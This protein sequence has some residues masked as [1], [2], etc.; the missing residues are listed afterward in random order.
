MG[1]VRRSPP[2]REVLERFF[3]L[4]DVDRELVAKRRGDHSRLLGF[5]LQLVTVR[6]VGYSK[7]KTTAS[8]RSLSNRHP[9]DFP[10]PLPHRNRLDTS[11]GDSRTDLTGLFREVVLTGQTE[12]ALAQVDEANERAETAEQAQTAA[13]AEAEAAN[14]QTRELRT[15][16]TGV[17]RDLDQ[18]TTDLTAART[19]TGAAIAER[20]Q[21]GRDLAATRQQLVDVTADRD[22]ARAEL[23]GVQADL[24]AAVARAEAAAEA[25]QQRLDDQAARHLQAEGT[26]QT[27]RAAKKAPGK[28]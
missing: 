10:A 23:A 5:A 14:D 9:Q 7:P 16:L 28:R 25:A 2:D 4:D 3:F 21:L 19:A 13:E 20:D 18:A 1:V 8:D 22:A 11:P 27:G 26:E 12:D 17:R 15:E 6:Q 24:A